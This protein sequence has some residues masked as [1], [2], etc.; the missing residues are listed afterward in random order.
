MKCIETP[1][2]QHQ[3]SLR[4]DDDDVRIIRNPNAEE[5]NSQI[6]H[7][8]H[9]NSIPLTIALLINTMI[10]ASIL[11][12]PYV[13]GKSGVIG[14]LIGLIIAGISTWYGVRMLTEA[15]IKCNTLE[16]GTLAFYVFGKNG[17]ILCD[18]SI[19]LLSFGSLISYMLI[20][21]QTISNILTLW[22]CH[23]WVC[24]RSSDVIVGVLFL[25]TPFCMLRRFGNFAWISV[26]STFVMVIIVF[27]ILI[28]SPLEY[29]PNAG[30][31]RYF[32]IR[33]LISSF[34]SIIFSVSFTTDNFQAFIS[35]E[36]TL[37]SIEKWKFITCFATT[38]GSLSIFILALAGYLSFRNCTNQNIL[39]NFPQKRYTFFQVIVC[40]HHVLGLP[41]RFVIMRYSFCKLIVGKRSEEIPFILH[42]FLTIFLL[43][44]LAF[45]SGSSESSGLSFTL[46]FSGGIGGSISCFILP[47][48]IYLKVMPKGS[49]LSTAAYLLFI[50]G[51]FTVVA[52]FV[53]SSIRIVEN[54]SIELPEYC[55]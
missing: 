26:Y 31:V 29:K 28:G 18:I 15:G 40:I 44:S 50:I 36:P 25:D 22:G 14:G 47:S 8:N 10:G 16:Y 23:K 32:D 30:S 2:H 42:T 48:L 49:S 45:I 7:H 39:D 53:E 21:G 20:L 27:F 13:F 12:Q 17:E 54:N 46:N 6:I 3:S 52:I 33:G 11:N 38:C 34:G 37:R 24:L 19:V 41:T 1:L 43:L 5:I 35:T 9:N 4:I 51:I 55:D